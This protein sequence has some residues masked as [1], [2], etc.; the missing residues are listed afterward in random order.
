MAVAN[1]RIVVNAALRE[2]DIDLPSVDTSYQRD[3]KPKHAK[4]M[5]DFDPNALGVPLIGEREDGSMWIVDGLQRITALR[6]MGRKKLRAE[7]FAS[8]GPEHEAKVFKLVNLNRTKLTA[9][10]EFKALLTAHDQTCWDIKNTVESMGFRLAQ[11]KSGRDSESRSLYLTC[12]STLR[13]VANNWGCDP[14]RFAL[15]TISDC[16]PGDYLG[17][18]NF[19]IEGLCVF[20]NRQDGAV[21][22]ERLVP[23][24]RSITPQR[25]LYQ[26]AMAQIG[27]GNKGSC[28]ADVIERVYRKRIQA[29][30]VPK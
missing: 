21:D 30:K 2:I 8:D 26:A 23:R 6:K 25:V 22:V 10:E 9:A 14:I 16:W 24:L 3:I 19:I 1:K 27:T 7:I 4:I 17:V 5:A 20:F 18:G 13:K 15:K 12:F 29:K 28:V 11:Y